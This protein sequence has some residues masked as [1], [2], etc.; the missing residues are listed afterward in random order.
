MD[1]F[2][3]EAVFLFSHMVT[4]TTEYLL[5]RQYCTEWLERVLGLI[6]LGLNFDS[7]TTCELLSKL[8][9]LS[10]LLFKMALMITTEQ[11]YCKD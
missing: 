5:E 7:A 10:F 2:M 8:F 4:M 3:S 9:T 1:V 11:I 6:D